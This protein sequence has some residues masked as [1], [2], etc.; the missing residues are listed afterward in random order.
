MSDEKDC[1]EVN[2]ILI[3]RCDPRDMA[4]VFGMNHPGG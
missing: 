1:N 2:V 3:G 4:K